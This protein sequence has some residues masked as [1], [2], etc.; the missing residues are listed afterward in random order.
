MTNAAAPYSSQGTIMLRP[1]RRFLPMTTT[2]IITIVISLATI[3]VAAAALDDSNVNANATTKTSR[4]LAPTSTSSNGYHP[5]SKIPQSGPID[6]ATCNVEQLEEANDSQLF[7]ILEDLKATTFFRNFA[8]DL[9]AN[10][11]L[12]EWVK[13]KKSSHSHS[14]SKTKSKTNEKKEAEKTKSDEKDVDVDE[15]SCTSELPDADPDGPAACSL[16]SNG[17]EMSWLTTG[18]S[19]ESDFESASFSSS[20]PVTTD[21]TQSEESDQDQEEEGNSESEDQNE[22][23]FECDGGSVADEMEDDSPPLCELTESEITQLELFEQSTTPIQDLVSSALHAMNAKLG[24]DSED[25]KDTFMWSKRTDPV[26]LSLDKGEDC[27]DDGLI[28]GALPDTFW[29]D[30]C[31][32]IKEGDGMKVV[33]L[34]LNPERNTGYNGTHIWRAIYEENCIDMDGITDQPMC[35]EE[36]VLYR[37]LSGLHASTTLSIAKNY[38][39]PNK[40]KGRETWEANPKYF[41]EQFHDHPEYIRNLHFSYVVLLRALKKASPVLYKYQ[42]KTGNIV[43]D[44]TATVLLRRLLDSSILTS[45]N[46]VFHAFDESLMFSTEGISSTDGEDFDDPFPANPNEIVALQQNFK[47]VF[48][49]VSSILDCVQCQQC[50]LHGKMAMLGYGTALKILFTSKEEL[51]AGSLNRNEIVALINTVAKMSEALI[52]VRELTHLYWTTEIETTSAPD[53]PEPVDAAIGLASA[54][55]KAGLI[56]AERE[57]ELVNAAMTMNEEFLDLANQFSLDLEKFATLSDSVGNANMEP[58]AIVIGTGLAGLA[59]TLNILDRGGRVT[60][61]EKEHRL[62]GNSNKASS[63]INACCPN[64]GTTADDIMTFKADTTK[65]AGSAAQPELIQTLV[66]NSGPAVVWLKERVGVDL[67]LIAQLGGHKHK[68][69]HRPKNGMVGAE[70]IYGMQKAVRQYE[71]SGMVKIITDT[72]VTEL[73]R[74]ENRVVGVRLDYLN[75]N[76]DDRPSQLNATSVILATGGFAADRTNESYLA[77]YRPELLKMPATAGAFSTGDGITL[78]KTLG[79]GLVDM[80]KVQIHP[81]GWVDPSDPHNQ[82]KILAAELMRGVGGMLINDDGKRFCNELGTRAY[83]TDKMLSHDEDYARS[84]KWNITNEIPTFALVLS[85]SA[86]DDG[87]K[88]VDHYSHKGLLTKIE[89]IDELAKWMAQDVEQLRETFLQYRKDAEEGADQWGK[90]SFQGLP[91][92]DLD[93]EVFY[94]GRVTPVL[95]YCMGG[96]TIDSE[97]NVLDE[98]KNIIQGLYAAGEVTGGVHGNNRLGGNSLLECTVFGTIVGKRVPVKDRK[99]I[100]LPY[101]KPPKTAPKLRDITMTELATHNTEDDCWVS[102]YGKVYDLTNFAEEHPAGAQS[103]YDLGGKDGTEAFQSVHNEG[104]MEDFEEVLLGKLIVD[105]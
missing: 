81:T 69:T 49:N 17:N 35:Y 42:I 87:K 2:I 92:S 16:T 50:K 65:S 8:V 41:Y 103:I 72:K 15:G 99:R 47:G 96:I 56:S 25:Q 30:L 105:S 43:D 23:N 24:W 104:M 7:T 18:A 10:C 82:N 90:K 38:Y 59:A 95:H 5:L 98:D 29:L 37:L 32:N 86:A 64:N 9:D 45:C 68:R 80:D 78:A 97:G 20:P 26:V 70:V 101:S 58:D 55:A 62:G 88:H 85:S 13:S 60:L 48:H 53:L 34:M 57:L 21:N 19:S 14:D 93:N 94:A 83:V 52:D 61:I 100:A 4:E 89:G 77:S 75:G 1:K 6:D 73:V 76:N 11:P 46:N 27:D 54:L 102:I 39:P 44:E 22:D 36:R 63:G 66:E 84:G 33:D 12:A 67:S 51:I 31:A 40:R 74:S 91:S 3:V 28:N 71:K 79:A